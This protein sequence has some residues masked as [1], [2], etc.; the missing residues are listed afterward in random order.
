M[1]P[2]LCAVNPSIERKKVSP[3]LPLGLISATER[4]SGDTVIGIP[5]GVRCA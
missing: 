5:G 1:N 4:V 2:S 3:L